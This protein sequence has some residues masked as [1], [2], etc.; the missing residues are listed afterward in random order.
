MNRCIEEFVRNY[1]ENLREN[2]EHHNIKYD[3]N[4]AWHLEQ[5]LKGFIYENSLHDNKKYEQLATAVLSDN[6]DGLK[7]LIKDEDMFEF[8]KGVIIIYG[9]TMASF[10]ATTT[11][12]EEKIKKFVKIKN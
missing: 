11:K 4:L 12:Y 3:A 1:L 9:A 10:G 5:A 6:V 2:G 8:Y 7:D